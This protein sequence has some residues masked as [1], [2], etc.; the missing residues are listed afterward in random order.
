VYGLCKAALERLSVG[1]AA[2]LYEDN[3]AVNALAPWDNVPTPGASA[4]DLVEDYRLEPVEYIAEAALQLCAGEQQR[5]TGRVAYSQPL[6]A[7]LSV[8]PRSLSGGP[9]IPA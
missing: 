6:L 1:L 9:F 3:I 7:E 8:Q 2:E 4:H 5:L